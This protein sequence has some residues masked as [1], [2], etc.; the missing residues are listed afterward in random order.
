MEARTRRRHPGGCL[1]ASGSGGGSRTPLC[2]TSWREPVP[3]SLDHHVSIPIASRPRRNF[4]QRNARSL[5]RNETPSSRTSFALHVQFAVAMTPR[6]K[7]PHRTQR[8]RPESDTAVPDV[9]W[10]RRRQ[11]VWSGRHP[12]TRP[13]PSG[14]PRCTDQSMNGGTIRATAEGQKSARMHSPHRGERARTGGPAVEDQ[15]QAEH[16]PLGDAP[17]SSPSGTRSTL[18]G[19]VSEVS[20]RRE[21]RRCT[22]VSTGQAG[23]VEGRHC[24][25]RWPS[26]DR[27]PAG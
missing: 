6:A 11:P 20:A 3:R 8:R 16:P 24:A 18:T 25:P 17:G 21:D 4:S 2:G 22:W 5:R 12:R 27:L 15:P 26:C 14:T 13:G 23:Q 1:R 19:S 9:V 7:S 10:P